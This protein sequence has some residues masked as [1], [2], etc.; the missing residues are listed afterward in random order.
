M[1]A[2]LPA[3]R[4]H[5]ARGEHDLARATAGRGLRAAGADRLRTV[6]LLAVLLDAELG[7]GDSE[8]ATEVGRRLR[9]RIGAVEVPALRA[10][11]A[12]AGARLA[13]AS[14]EPAVAVSALE[15]ALDDLDADR[16]PW[17][18]ATLLLELA[19]VR[20]AAR[21]RPGATVD[22]R[23]AGALL[24]GLDVVV[25]P[26]DRA[27]LADLAPTAVA[28]LAGSSPPSH[29]AAPAPAEASLRCDGRW[30][31]VTVG[32][33]CVRLRA[34]KGLHYVA[35]LVARPGVERHVL[36]LVDR[37]EG[38]A[39]AGGPGRRSLGDAG[40]EL[41]ARARAAYRLRIEVLR[42]TADDALAA[43][44]L[45]GAEAAQAE[46]DQLVAQLA[47]AFGLGGRSRKAASAAERARLNVT[48]AVRSAT[49]AI[50]EALPG[51]G[52]ALDRRITTG[53]YCTYAPE[54]DDD[55]RWIV[56]P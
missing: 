19:R 33:T 16:A 21:D 50:D 47:R 49:R 10:R 25:R 5:L 24:A 15:D 37:V 29:D 1:E 6:E 42:A 2:L 26:E 39:A 53:R 11:A 55:L 23:A 13:V 12:S 34:T 38:V 45:D 52:A 43:H 20:S 28:G 14:G 56:H 30:W 4:L 36:D 18:R 8:A 3:A 54:P 17:R 31:E 40:E 35:D 41:D 48:R 46:I 32:A 27:L 51:A 44:D 22:A 9:E 7:R